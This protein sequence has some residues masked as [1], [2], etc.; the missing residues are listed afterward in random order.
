VRALATRDP[1]FELTD[2]KRG[3]TPDTTLRVA[4]VLRMP[5]DL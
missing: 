2:G 5:A 3:V 4:Q 1:R